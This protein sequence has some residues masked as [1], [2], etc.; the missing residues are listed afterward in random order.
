MV[1]PYTAG[2]TTPRLTR[3][4]LLQ[5]GFAAGTA[6][7]LRPLSRPS[8]LWGSETAPPKR[9][10][11][12]RVRGWDPVHFDP[13]LT[14]SFRT[15]TA[16]SFVYSKLLRHKVGESVRPGTFIVEPDLAERWEEPDDT[17]YIF[18]LRQGVR[19][20]NKPPVNGRELVAEDVKFTFD[21]FLTEKGNPER[22]LL[23]SV[24][25]VEVV[26][27][28]TVKFVLKEPFVWLL[29][30]LA[31][32]MMMWII[33][34]EVAGKYGDLKKVE[35]AIGTGPFLLEHYEPNV[36]TVFKRN[37]NYFRAGQPYVDQ[38]EWLVV[39]DESTALAMY[40]TGQIDAGPWNN[41]AV[42]QPDLESLKQSHPHLRFQDM[43]ATNATTIWMRT[44]QP[45]FSDVRVRRAISHAIDRQEM[46]EAV[47]MRGEPS[48]AV[49]RGLAE[50]SL[51]IDQL[52]DGAKYYRYDPQE[53]RRLLAEAGYA[54]GFKTVF[55]TTGGYGRDL[56][57]AAQVALRNLK[58]VGIEAELKLQEYGAYM[59]TTG[60]GK[61]EGM[62]MGPYVLGWEPDSSLY[63]P[64]TPDQ[65][66][67]R[68]HVNDSKLAAMVKEQRRLKDPEARKQLI[69]D[70][71]RQAAEQQYYVYLSSAMI[72]SSWQPYMKNYAHNLTFDY[73]S[74]I[75]ALWL[76]R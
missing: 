76:D 15:H 48:P 10:G 34:P 60:Q 25:R 56:V 58:E 33:A 4:A 41:W 3:R 31:N 55:T 7:S 67:N 51:P 23:E 72:T 75:A 6:L 59:A 43:L 63:G 14:R 68:G 54:K 52:G 40:R 38:V 69:F 61:F 32:A 45:P 19:W 74:R 18:H 44:D 13:H 35:T 26:D 64:Y 46:I 73:G 17:T 71:Q 1:T 36:K 27:R 62:A 53:S 65:P 70:I 57:D 21:R 22:Q 37:P 39:D 47:W 29:D 12:L 11:I 30:V 50:W 49:P 66:R 24:D 20:Q 42:R 9:G 16:L 8:L 2:R 28:Y 5:A